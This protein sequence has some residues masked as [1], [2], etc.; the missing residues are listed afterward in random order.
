MKIKNKV[1]GLLCVALAFMCLNAL[2]QKP[3]IDHNSYAQWPSLENSSN[4]KISNDGLYVL[5]TIKNQPVNKHTTFIRSIQNEWKL[6]LVDVSQC[7]FMDHKFIFQK[8]DT[9]GIGMLGNSGI[10]YQA[11]IKQF[12]RLEKGANENLLL[13][14]N[15]SPAKGLT[16]E[17][18]TSGFKRSYSNVVGYQPIA[19]SKFLALI[20]EKGNGIRQLQLLNFDNWISNTIWSGQINGVIS[21]LS[22]T[23][24]VFSGRETPE[25]DNAVFYYKEGEGSAKKL[26]IGLYDLVNINAINKDGLIFCQ[27]RKKTHLT[28]TNAKMVSLDVYSYK[29]GALQSGQ[30]LQKLSQRAYKAVINAENQQV[31]ILENKSDK[32]LSDPNE[33]TLNSGYVLISQYNSAEAIYSDEAYW[34]PAARSSIYLVSLKDGSKKLISK[35][36]EN[37]VIPFPRFF[38]SP[39][40]KYIIWYNA[41]NSNYFS[42]TIKTGVVANITGSIQATWT[43]GGNGDDTR[44]GKNSPIGI[45]SFLSNDDGLL[46]H[47]QR[48]IYRIDLSGHLPP[49]CVTH[50]YGKQH[51]IEFALTFNDSPQ[52]TLAACQKQLLVNAFD[53]AT[54]NDGFYRINL[55]GTKDPEYLTMQ[56]CLFAGIKEYEVGDYPPVKARDAES[57]IVMR[58]SASDAPNLFYTADFKNFKHLTNLSPQKPYN[59]LTSE[60]INWK[61]FN[62]TNSQGILY[63]PEN[64]DPQKKYPIIFFYYER[65]SNSLN[66]FLFPKANGAE[67]DIPTFVSKGYLV[68]VPD[69]HYELGNPGKSAYNSVVSAA[70]FLAKRAWVDSLNMGINGHSFGGY[71]TNYLVSHTHI[72][73]AA[74][75]GSGWSDFVSTYNDIKTRGNSRQYYYEIY[76]QRMRGTLWDNPQDYI[77]AS[78]IFRADQVN[79]PLLM[80]NNKADDDVHFYEGTEFFVG[81]RRLQ[82]KV[83]MLQYDGASHLIDDNVGALDFETR[84]EQFFDHYL[85]G[86]PPPYWMTRGIPAAMKGKDLGLETDTSGA[87]P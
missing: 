84:M 11:G 87:I 79:T 63:K 8:N 85:K 51:D 65:F 37:S 64:F 52:N 83:W 67:I 39:G 69:I 70:Q 15:N 16:I 33:N 81:L 21:D 77:D 41:K 12:D 76:R 18:T 42:Y 17:S 75:A 55:D 43:D 29:D 1:N 22:G 19:N 66:R 38:F 49:I 26:D 23:K 46:L 68:F 80:M 27:V 36:L 14:L 35:D 32:M 25:A 34:N 60:I 31:K 40:G 50:H 3:P 82:K 61:T 62:G 4:I 10:A 72:F 30:L 56:P 2:A 6:A 59:W 13:Y 73:K 45:A 5:Y 47:D 78:P 74:C 86:A 54:K 24:I 7:Q 58:Q 28:T 44:Q 71:E 9:I 20:V 53:H 57:Y 48:D